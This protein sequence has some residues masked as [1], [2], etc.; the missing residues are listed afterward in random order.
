RLDVTRWREDRTC[1][2]GGQVVYVRDAA[3]GAGWA[4]GYQPVCKPAASYEAVFSIDKAELRR[5]DGDLET[6]LEVT[7]STE[8]PAEV[9]RVTVTNH[10]TTP[11]VVELTSYVELALQ[12]HGADLAHPAFGKL[13]L[14]TE[15]LPGSDA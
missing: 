10:G 9:R 4:A 5:R 12:S 6:L 1:D 8:H 15:A 2:A 14:E 3:T 7:V 13:F 11:R